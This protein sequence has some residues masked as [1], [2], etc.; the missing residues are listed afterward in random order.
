MDSPFHRELALCR[1]EL[2]AGIE[3]VA[4]RLDLL[5]AAVRVLRSRNETRLLR[6]LVEHIGRG[7][8]QA[9][10]AR[11]NLATGEYGEACEA[12]LGLI[13]TLRDGIGK[14]DNLDEIERECADATS[15]G[16]TTERRKW[17]EIEQ[18]VDGL[19]DRNA[20]LTGLLTAFLHAHFKRSSDNE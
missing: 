3:R 8:V 19:A 11:G 1:S 7:Q 5:A 17:S 20:D 16:E 9:Q 12:I 14:R 15:G 10:S 4:Q 2:D 6:D 13:E 18:E